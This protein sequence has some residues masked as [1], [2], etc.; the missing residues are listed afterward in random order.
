MEMDMDMDIQARLDNINACSASELN[1]LLQQVASVGDARASVYVYDA[2]R[3]RKVTCDSASWEALRTLERTRSSNI[4]YRVATRAGALAPS[5]RI[6]K[7]CKGSRLHDRSEAAKESMPEAITYVRATPG[8]SGLDRIA[9]AKMIS[10]ALGI[11][12]EHARGVVT[13]LKQ[14]GNL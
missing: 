4:A 1:S 10:V 13:K 11:P 6:H 3:L 14:T 7:I 8:F 9:Q 5:R 2:M 12:F